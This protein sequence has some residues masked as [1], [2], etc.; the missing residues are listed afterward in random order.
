MLNLGPRS[1]LGRL[2]PFPRVVVGPPSE[3]WTAGSQVSALST[4]AAPAACWTGRVRP[5]VLGAQACVMVFLRGRGE[6][7]TDCLD[8]RALSHHAPPLAS[9]RSESSREP[10]GGLPG[11][12]SRT[13]PAPATWDPVGPTRQDIYLFF[14]CPQIPQPILLIWASRMR[15]LF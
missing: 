7:L 9:S 5:L 4:T 14:R 8:C 2:L 12:P 15:E 11:R 13:Q 1:L 6:R 10:P 3:K